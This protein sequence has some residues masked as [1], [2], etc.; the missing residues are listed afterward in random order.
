MDS[1]TNFDDVIPPEI[2]GKFKE[3]PSIEEY[4]RIRR[5]YPS[6]KLEF[7]STG[8]IEFLFHS[9]RHLEAV[10]IDPGI[11]ASSLDG[12]GSAQSEISL[13]LLEKITQRHKIVKSGKTH[14][15]SR[16]EA[17]S[18]SFINYLIGSMLDSIV[19]NDSE[20][21][22]PDLIVLIK[23]QIRISQSEYE[24]ELKKSQQRSTAIY[25][26]A[27]MLTRGEIPSYRRIA[28]ILK[29]EA[30]TVQRWFVDNEMLSKAKEFA[31]LSENFKIRPKTRT[32]A[33]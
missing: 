28:K 25:L 10:G 5:E 3:N 9:Q 11:F 26:A 31:S 14:V 15:V 2:A 22:S 12:D 32:V 16:G 27:Q 1:L 8:G 7:Y 4:I 33:S 13:I 24:I 23:A 20:Y 19:W 17:I 29:V 6:A 18:D 21:I 30:S